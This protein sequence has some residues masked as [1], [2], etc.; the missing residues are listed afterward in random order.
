MN[1]EKC[2]RKDITRSV[3]LTRTMRENQFWLW[4]SHTQLGS[5]Q[6]CQTAAR[7]RS[8]LTAGREERVKWGEAGGKM[9]MG[10]I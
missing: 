8:R 2:I 6:C 7:V 3:V 4:A 10:P 9:G 1:R 5:L